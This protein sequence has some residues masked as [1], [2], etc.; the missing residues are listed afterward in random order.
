MV[1]RRE[2]NHF[3]LQL[4]FFNIACFF[5]IFP[6]IKRFVIMSYNEFYTDNL[7]VPSDLRMCSRRQTT[8]LSFG[9]DLSDTKKPVVALKVKAFANQ[10]LLVNYT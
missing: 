3:T 8:F 6:H 9:L 10:P 1:C 5:Y 2:V 4:L 7:L